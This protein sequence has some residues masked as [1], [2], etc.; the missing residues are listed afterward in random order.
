MQATKT[1]TLLNS[2]RPSFLVLAPACVLLGIATAYFGGSEL[3]TIDICLVLIG[4]L[5]AHISVNSLNE[6]HDFVSGLDEKTLRT[7]FSGGSGALVAH[8]DAATAVRTLGYLFLAITISTGLYFA[9]QH[10]SMILPFGLLGVVIILAYT[11]VLNRYP[12]LCLLAPGIGFGPLMVGGTHVVLSGNY[13][14]T[15]ILASLVPM[16]L[17]SNLLLLNQYPDI[18]ADK[19]VG[20]FH[21]PIAYGVK[22]STQMYGL[23]VLLAAFTLIAGVLIK[24]LPILS[25]AA[26]LPLIPAAAA[27]IGARK[28]ANNIK[29]LTPFLAMNVIA[30]IVTPIILSLALFFS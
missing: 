24:S 4:A 27:Y 15:A 6:Y 28:H 26:L 17:V 5:S 25:L 18:E 9:Y 3:N 11:P 7:P 20:R 30:A 12:V 19:S 14:E 13:N 8:P 10:G 22:H 21:F 29:A 1:R 2:T 23:F 16:F